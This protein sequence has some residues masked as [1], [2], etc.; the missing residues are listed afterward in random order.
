MISSNDLNP[1]ILSAFT[2]EITWLDASTRYPLAEFIETFYATR[3]RTE[4]NLAD[5]TD[6]QMAYSSPAHS[7]WSISETVTHLI[8]TQN[9]Y[10]NKLL[11]LSTSQLPHK[12]EA[13]RGFGE[14]AQSSIPALQLRED[15]AKATEQIRAAIADTRD[16]HNPEKT[17]N[18]PFGICT[19]KT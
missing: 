2:K 8:Y 6:K 11:E 15:M 10:Y 14:G 16:S 5:L 9:F 1:L 17:E 12:S 4:E 3:E 7:L 13:A 18:G 19:Y